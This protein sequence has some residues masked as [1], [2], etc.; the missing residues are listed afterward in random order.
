MK[1]E[2]SPSK[3][4]SNNNTAAIIIVSVVAI[5]SIAVVALYAINK[6]ARE[7]NGMMN[8]NSAKQNPDGLV[9]KDSSEYKMFSK[10]KGSA[11]DKMFLGDM[12][13]HHQG[14]IDMS[15]LA[16]TYA[17]H[18]EIK[19]L[20]NSIVASQSK[21]IDDMAQWQKAWGYPSTTGMM[22][23]D[24]SA[25]HMMSEMDSMTDS[26]KGLSGDAFDKAFLA[27]MIEHHQS[28]IDMSYP[29]Q[30]NAQ[31]SELKNL[32]KSIVDTQ[33]REI[34]QMRQWQKDWGY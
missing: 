15:A 34:L 18:Q 6:N 31:H 26:L 19:D 2:A 25:M 32:T 9:N 23:E 30:T 4:K 8:F 5:I 1:R 11:Y 21:E 3:K 13:N 22:M 16:L 17:K 20:A 7:I 29:G 10:V 12:I 24:H 27:L 33:S 14:A 28:A